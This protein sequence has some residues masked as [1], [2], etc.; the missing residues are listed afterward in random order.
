MITKRGARIIRAGIA[1]GR[2]FVALAE[3]NPGLTSHDLGEDLRGLY[4]KAYS[5]TVLRSRKWPNA[6]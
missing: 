4:G 2:K 6:K 5:H 3:A 1:G